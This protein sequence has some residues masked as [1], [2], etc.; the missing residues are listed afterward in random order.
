MLFRS[1]SNNSVETEI[2]SRRTSQVVVIGRFNNLVPLQP[3]ELDFTLGKMVF[4]L[5]IHWSYTP[6]LA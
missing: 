4:I 5:L 6:Y 1:A 2:F 3:G